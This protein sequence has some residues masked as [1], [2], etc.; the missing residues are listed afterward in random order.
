MWNCHKEVS[1]PHI[2]SD[3]AKIEA[4]MRVASLREATDL[5]SDEAK[6]TSPLDPSDQ[7]ELS[8]LPLSLTTVPHEAN[9]RGNEA[10]E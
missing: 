4:E 9:Y 10:L 7:Q 1:I 2:A 8:D 6:K 5:I 3:A